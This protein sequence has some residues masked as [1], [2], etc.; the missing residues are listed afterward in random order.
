MV[1]SGIEA[2]VS[3]TPD[4]KH[5][6]AYYMGTV[7]MKDVEFRIHQSGV[8]RAQK[9]QV[10][11]V[12]AWAVGEIMHEFPEQHPPTPKMLENLTQVTYHYNVGR[13]IEVLPKGFIGPPRDMTNGTYRAAFFCGRDFYVS[14]V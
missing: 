14:K 1:N 2:C 6:R 9:E 10:R 4:K 5:G 3:V 13:F 7:S 8:L 11:N 12:H